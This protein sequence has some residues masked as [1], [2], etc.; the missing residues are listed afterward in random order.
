[1]GCQ[2]LC[3]IQKDNCQALHLGETNTLERYTLGSP[4]LGRSSEEKD[5]GVFVG[6]KVNM[7]RQ[8]SL[9]AM[10]ATASCPA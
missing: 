6:S 10:E 1:M 5:L 2:D 9:A 4:W 7:S 8:H 3:E